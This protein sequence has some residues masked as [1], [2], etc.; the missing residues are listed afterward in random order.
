MWVM[1]EKKL[2]VTFPHV[3]I[4]LRIFLSTTDTNRSGERSFFTLKI[5]K[6]YQRSTMGQQR[7]SALALLQIENEVLNLID[8]DGVINSLSTFKFHRKC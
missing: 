8:M 1:R 7:F 4:A 5:I 6:N 2:Q 3:D